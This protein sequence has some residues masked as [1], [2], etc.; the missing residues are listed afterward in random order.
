MLIKHFKSLTALS[1]SR[2]LE[3]LFLT[4]R[5]SWTNRLY[6][7]VCYFISSRI[8]INSN[9]YMLNFR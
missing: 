3:V 8:L 6:W 5:M 1:L 2:I 9:W 7:N 4:R